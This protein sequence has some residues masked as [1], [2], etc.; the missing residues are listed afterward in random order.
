MKNK[1]A[2]TIRNIDNEKG[3]KLNS[4]LD[5]RVELIKKEVII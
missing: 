5:N 2:E 3:L 4:R 1:F